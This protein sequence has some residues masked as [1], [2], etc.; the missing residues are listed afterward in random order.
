MGRL[1]PLHSRSFSFLLYKKI[2]TKQKE[3]SSENCPHAHVL[4]LSSNAGTGKHLVSSSY[5]S[6]APAD[7]LLAR[8]ER[9]LAAILF[10]RICVLFVIVVAECETIILDSRQRR[11]RSRRCGRF[12]ASWLAVLSVGL[13]TEFAL[14]PECLTEFYGEFFP[15]SSSLGNH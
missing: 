6:L 13:H 2:L 7:F 5:S 9:L 11:D 4:T 10:S 15:V 3:S 8:S 14:P 12:V 1:S